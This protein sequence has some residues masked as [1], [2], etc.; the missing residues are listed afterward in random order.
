MSVQVP[1]PVVQFPLRSFNP[2]TLA[3]CFPTDGVSRFPDHP[4]VSNSSL[5]SPGLF[6]LDILALFWISASRIRFILGGYYDTAAAKIG[7]AGF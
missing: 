3:F 6:D 1:V 7:C 5:Y 2:P 4:F